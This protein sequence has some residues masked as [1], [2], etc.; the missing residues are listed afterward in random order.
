[1]VMM[2]VMV[3]ECCQLTTH[4][5]NI[6]DSNQSPLGII[7]KMSSLDVKGLNMTNTNLE[8]LFKIDPNEWRA[9]VTRNRA[10]FNNIKTRL[11]QEIVTEGDRLLQRLDGV[12]K[13]TKRVYA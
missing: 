9:E 2:M 8:D 11:P 4:K 6:L 1:M 5:S 10:F 13:E 7:P 3:L 12:E